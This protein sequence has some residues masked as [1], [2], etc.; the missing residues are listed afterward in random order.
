ME[1]E[2][3]PSPKTNWLVNILIFIGFIVAVFTIV[4]LC[5]E[6]D[7]ATDILSKFL[8]VLIV[9]GISI[10]GNYIRKLFSNN[11]EDKK[12]TYAPPPHID[13]SKNNLFPKEQVRIQK[14]KTQ[15]TDTHEDYHIHFTLSGPSILDRDWTREK[16]KD[17]KINGLFPVAPVKLKKT[18]QTES[19]QK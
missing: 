7:T 18:S 5:F 6:R 4:I 14:R 8:F 9:S 12:K 1:G 11:T 2:P 15:P 10:I 16:E 13:P 3:T 19:N 17:R